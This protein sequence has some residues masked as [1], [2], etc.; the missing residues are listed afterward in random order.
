MYRIIPKNGIRYRS[1]YHALFPIS[2]NRLTLTEAETIRTGSVSIVVKI[3][4]IHPIIGMIDR[5]EI[6]FISMI[7]VIVKVQNSVLV[8]RPSNLNISFQVL[9]YVAMYSLASMFLLIEKSPL[10]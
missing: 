4:K 2:C 5:K 7:V 3:L 1:Q 8:V 9:I 6:R 10:E